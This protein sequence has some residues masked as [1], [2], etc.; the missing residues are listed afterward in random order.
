[1]QDSYLLSPMQQGMLF[2]SLHEQQSGVDLEQ[3]VCTLHERLEVEPLI[4]AW[5]Q[6]VARH[7]VLRTSFQWDGLEEPTQQVQPNVSLPFTQ[8]DWR[9]LA[10]AEQDD[11][12][13]TYLQ[14]DRLR[15]FDLTHA[16]SCV[17]PCFGWVTLSFV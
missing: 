6:V 4:Q 13:T 17:L 15:G 1:M 12:H 14:T 10:V 16:P 8:H 2:H 7:P 9:D 5:Q 11:R 3:V